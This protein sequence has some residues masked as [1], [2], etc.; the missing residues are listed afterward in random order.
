MKFKQLGP[1]YYCVIAAAFVKGKILPVHILKVHREKAELHFFFA[2]ALN[3]V[4]GSESHT[5]TLTFRDAAP[6]AH[7]ITEW[8][9]PTAN[10]HTLEKKNVSCSSWELNHDSSVM[11]ILLIMKTHPQ[12]SEDSNIFNV[13]FVNVLIHS[14]QLCLFL[15]KPRPH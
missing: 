1:S 4:E 2:F 7:Q 12:F 6:S 3:G 5:A 10:Q 14:V 15:I 11:D 13:S 9:G 8:V